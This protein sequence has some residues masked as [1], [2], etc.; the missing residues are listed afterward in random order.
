MEG[1]RSKALKASKIGLFNGYS[2]EGVWYRI[3]K[4][5]GTMEI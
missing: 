2:I 3:W 1:R 4:M 5:M